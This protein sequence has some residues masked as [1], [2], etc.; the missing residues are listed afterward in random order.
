MNQKGM[1]LVELVVV[2]ALVAAVALASAIYAVSWISRERARSA[3]YQLQ[4]FMQLARI[5]AVSR[6]QDCRFL[7]DVSTRTLQ[8][9][10]SNGTSTAA[11]DILLHETRLPE[12]VT[13]AR[14]DSGNAVTLSQIGSTSVYETVFSSDGVVSLGTG[15][16][17]L[18][19]GEEF[20]RVQVQGAG[21]VMVQQW[22]GSTWGSV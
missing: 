1:T 3:V 13:F 12:V 15:I 6:N 9:L 14:P 18:Y 20:N 5:E 11:D 10:D 16:V 17:A 7:V 8:V 4:S 19:G 2:V 22:D 21:G